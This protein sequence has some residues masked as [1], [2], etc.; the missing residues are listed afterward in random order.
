MKYAHLIKLTAF[1]Y[2]DDNNQSI[3]DA[4]LKFFPFSLEDNKVILKKTDAAGFND[5]KIGIFEATLTKTNLT[6]QFLKNFL[7]NLDKKQKNKVL[8]QI[9]SR[10]DKNLDFFL[11]FEKNLWINDKKLALTDS[12]NCFHIKINIA[13]FPKKRKVALNVIKDMFSGK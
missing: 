11:R 8:Q 13:A 4:F 5:K 2:E 10:L 3:L 12:G 6:N 1:S 7:N 9:K